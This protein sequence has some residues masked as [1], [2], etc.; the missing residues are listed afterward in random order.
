MEGMGRGGCDEI[1]RRSASHSHSGTDRVGPH[2]AA[3]YPLLIAGQQKTS[4]G[5]QESPVPSPKRLSDAPRLG[6]ELN[7]A[8]M[9]SVIVCV[10]R[11]GRETMKRRMDARTACTRHLRWI[12]RETLPHYRPLRFADW[13]AA[14][15]APF[16]LR[17]TMSTT[18]CC[19][20]ICDKKRGAGR[21]G[22]VISSNNGLTTTCS[23]PNMGPSGRRMAARNGSRSDC[24]T[25]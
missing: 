2:K 22:H 1:E 14:P 24:T 6:V 16:L 8:R 7:D 25:T 17:D 3:L 19:G 20:V 11:T 15:T 21:S 18:L 10:V 4:A 12:I 13:P 5:D 9:T 23:V